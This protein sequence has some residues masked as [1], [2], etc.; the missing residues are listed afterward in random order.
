MAATRHRAGAVFREAADEAN[1]KLPGQVR[2]QIRQTVGAPRSTPE[3]EM[4]TKAPGDRFMNNARDNGHDIFIDANTRA[5]L[6]RPDFRDAT[7]DLPSELRQKL[8]YAM[9]GNMKLTTSEIDIIRQQVRDWGDAAVGNKGSAQEIQRELTNLANRSSPGYELNTV[10]AHESGKLR[11]EGFADGLALKPNTGVMGGTIRENEA[12]AGYGEG[13]ARRA[14]DKAGSGTNGARQALDEIGESKNMQDALASAYG[15]GATDDLVQGARALRSGQKALDTIAPQR[16]GSD[17][18][19][20]AKSFGDAAGAVVATTHGSNA[21]MASRLI[22]M[23]PGGMSEKTAERMAK[24]LVDPETARQGVA[25]LRR[26]G[27]SN[28][29]IAELTALGARVGGDRIDIARERRVPL[30]VTV[31]PRRRD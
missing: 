28:E 15:H 16:V 26:A 3:M 23:L 12:L 13:V 30:E 4:A 25:N 6:N 8:A 29:Q 20:A 19:D 27:A 22:Q 2:D 17:T 1:E 9:D 11:E 24:M 7:R 10:R 5:N 31:R 21:S 18:L 14:W